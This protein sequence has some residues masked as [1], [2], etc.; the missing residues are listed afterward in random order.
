MR[1]GVV[2]PVAS[3]VVTLIVK[4]GG[5]AVGDVAGLE[6][7]PHLNEEVVDTVRVDRAPLYTTSVMVPLIDGCHRSCWL[8]IRIWTNFCADLGSARRGRLLMYHPALNPG[9]DRAAHLHR[10]A[11]PHHINWRTVPA[12]QQT[13]GAGSASRTPILVP[14][15]PTLSGL[16]GLNID[17]LGVNQVRDALGRRP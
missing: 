2:L 4:R 15:A 5:S 7:L 3:A 8:Q 9:A 10:D 12:E 11:L 13:P 1:G 14:H 6:L 17:L 16:W